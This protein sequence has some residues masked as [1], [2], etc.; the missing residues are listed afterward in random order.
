MCQHPQLHCISMILYSNKT[1]ELN[2][3]SYFKEHKSELKKC[4]MQKKRKK[5]KILITLEGFLWEIT[6]KN[7]TTKFICLSFFFFSMNLMKYDK[8][9]APVERK[10]D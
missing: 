2:L 10:P 3:I 7:S 4:F 6:L 1:K 9:E 8:L 5:K